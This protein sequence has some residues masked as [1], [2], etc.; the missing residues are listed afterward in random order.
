[1]SRSHR[2]K[3]NENFRLLSVSDTSDSEL[4]QR[5]PSR[6]EK[7][8]DLKLAMP[9]GSSANRVLSTAGK[10][11]R[12]IRLKRK[13]RDRLSNGIHQ[14]STMSTTSET[15]GSDIDDETCNA[16]D[17]CLACVPSSSNMFRSQCCH[18][19]N[20]SNHR[21]AQ[22][23]LWLHAFVLFLFAVALASLAYYTMTLQN[24]LAILRINLDPV[25]DD[26]ISYEKNQENLQTRLSL[27]ATNHSILRDNLTRIINKVDLL[28]SQM[29]SLN[30]SVASVLTS[31]ANA[32][33]LKSV[34]ADIAD[35]KREFGQFGS[36]LTDVETQ[37]TSSSEELK[38][39]QNIIKSMPNTSSK[40]MV[41]DEVLSQIRLKLEDKV[42][43][44]TSRLDGKIRS[45]VD[46]FKIVG[47]NLTEQLQKLEIRDQ[48]SWKLLEQLT[49]DVQN[50][51][52]K[53]SSN[54]IV[55]RTNQAD[56]V[57]LKQEEM[58]KLHQSTPKTSTP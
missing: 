30:N 18:S 8:P 17:M 10:I 54:E 14:N 7:V 51:S 13:Q 20:S 12:K 6:T 5:S 16:I 22:R 23:H 19:R 24:Q 46:K 4:K 40:Q 38:K 45:A 29:H 49:N 34:P 37:T 43:N 33:Q 53:A 55:S 39:M 58:E 42:S 3:D 25:L 44:E 27:L 36:R 56:I 31:L 21:S 48:K 1:M 41:N 26:K 15:G 52:A 11:R 35:L 50:I 47:T 32:P 57:K 9:S 2:D 28:S